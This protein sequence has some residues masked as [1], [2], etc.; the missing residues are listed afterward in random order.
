MSGQIT[1]KEI[2]EDEAIVWGPEY[3]KNVDLA[4]KKNKEFVDSI[5]SLVEANNKLRGSS[6][7]KELAENQRKVNDVS[8]KTSV[9]WKEQIQLENA[10]ISTKKKNQLASEGTNRALTKER[11]LLAESN[12]EIKRQ[13]IANGALE[14]AY[15][16][17][18]AQVAIS[19]DKIKNIIS[20]GKLASESQSQ[21]NLRLA[22]AQKEFEKLNTRVRAADAA[23]GTFNRNVGNYPQ[24]A[25]AGLKNLI[26][27]FGAVT[28]IAL[29]ASVVKDAFNATRDFEKEVVNLAAIAG[30]SRTEI[31]PLESKIREV[32]KSSINGATDVAKLAT[33]LI[34]LGSSTEEAE[35]LLEPVNN[36]S[37]ALQASAE[38]SATLV[39]SILNSYG[40]GAEEAS[41]VTDVLAESANRSALDFQG[42]RDSFSY[43][44]PAA[45]ALGIPVE[46]T[47]AIIGTLA[48]NGIK[49]ESAGRLT[50]TAF[51]RL[52]AQGLT[53]ED[54][55]LKI[56]TAQ[57]EGKSNL[58]VLSLATNL[59]G[60]EAGKI[61]LILANNVVKIDQST[62]AYENSGGALKE[63]TDKQLKSL[64][65]ELKIL[66]SAWEDY[67]LGTNEATGAS[68]KVSSVV[69][70]LSTNLEVIFTVLGSLA[71][72][73]L[74]YKAAVLLANVQ[75]RLLALT[76]TQATIAQEA[77][78]VVTG[79]GTAAQTANAAATTFAT[80]AWERFNLALKANALGLII[81]ALV[82]VIYY[83]DKYNKSLSELNNETKDSTEEFLKNREQLSKNA[84][85]TKTL[86]DR[87]DELKSKTKLNK[88][89]QIELNEIV[90]TLSKTYP[91]AV[92]KIDKYGDAIELNTS[93]IKNFTIAQNEANKAQASVEIQKNTKL[94]KELEKQQASLAESTKEGGKVTK[95]IYVQ[96]GQLYR[97]DFDG[98]EFYSTKLSLEEAANFKK[99]VADNERAVAQTKQRIRDLK[100]LTE[101][102]KVAAKT[103]DENSK[104][105]TKNSVRTIE[106]I[107]AE[108][109]AQ[110]DLVK[111]L[112]DKSGKE[113]R[114]IK[115][116]IANLTAER[117]LIY[118]TA[119]AEK[120]KQDNG[121]KNAKKVND[122]LYNLNQFRYQN[123]IN[124]NQKII[125]SEKATNEEKVNALLE[126][127][128]L[129]ESKNSETLQN[130][131]YKNALEI[132]GL[133]NLSKEKFDLYQKDAKNRIE[134]ILSGKIAT[135]KLTNDEKLILE[136]YYA[137][138]KN[139]EE[140]SSKDKQSIIDLEVARVQK[141]IDAELLAQDTKIQEALDAENTLYQN[142][143]EAAN[144]NQ[145]LIE[146]AE[147]EHQR[148]LFEIK[149]DFAK[150]GLKLQID[151]IKQLLDDDKKKEGSSKISTEKRLEYEN[152]L[153][154]L[155]TEFNQIG[156]DDFKLNLDKRAEAQKVFNEKVTELSLQLKDEL[157]N[158][159]NTI[160]EAKIS[161]ID[162]EISKNNEFYDNQIK[163]AE[164]DA[165][166]K[167]FLEKER[168]R[169]NE[170]LEKK[171]K[172]AQYEQAVFNKIMAI[173]NIGI[174]TAMA[175][176][177]AL[178]P[179]PVGLGPVA[180]GA[181]LPYIIGVGAIQAATVLA[182]PLPKYKHGRKGGP[183]E[184]A[185]VGDGGVSEIITS[186][187][188]SNPRLT[189]NVPTLT[190]LG[191]D[192]IVHK[193]MSDYENYVKQSIILNFKN[194]NQKIKELNSGFENNFSK[195]LLEEMKRN[196]KAIEKGKP[197]ILKNKAIDIPHSIWAF[198][199][200]NW[201]A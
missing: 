40:L 191:K 14:S 72:A 155:T 89:E 75:T 196:T 148:R 62:T 110:E 125:D 186:G 152:K 160:F 21:Y 9:I 157:I 143:L 177:A 181:L 74:A 95:G 43:L 83:L 114:A 147:E 26:S 140:K 53:L 162:D 84:S 25:V 10:L 33:E 2:I 17:L 39:K 12:S 182:A 73:W 1:R 78:V 8:E 176:I 172:K 105:S 102:E 23:V 106:V 38:D 200:I 129:Q 161:S 15:K 29:F 178:A 190:K 79:F 85:S 91:E 156:T 121:L 35:K 71:T 113:G 116:K 128:Q 124:N 54:A 195:E 193:S 22:V 31:A 108:I 123:E 96:N 6:N 20:T 138:K 65:S 36:L 145:K 68:Q 97:R 103:A 133:E 4:V 81:A 151:A 134:S 47:A 87:Y 164:N 77:N 86:T 141:S 67:I 100:G 94:L 63:L 76:T 61:G 174:Q 52:A 131:L 45:R 201:R 194:E 199:N 30:K 58:E 168:D 107:D 44:A 173:A 5:I 159:A 163:L 189:P 82:A 144:G 57:K 197:I 59:F 170:V 169:K 13:I 118:S 135:E 119:K 41:R 7:A 24:Q 16:K 142:A 112:S 28:G 132:D 180:G 109:K 55:L 120:E 46:K 64:D 104:T 56:N 32:S 127:N 184:L 185:I 117:E 34:K 3:A 179:P 18:A 88:E 154:K 166:K 158:F 42:L 92:T 49:A 66:S 136:K 187:D 90:K 146:K 115:S 98:R 93:K 198:R 183:A 69:K 101:A 192:D 80:S 50:S 171:K 137:E 99:R 139:L 51:S 149:K 70:F 111:G 11:V 60:A 165:R 153:A 167:D 37:V 130:D 122:A 48:D 27:A 19:G 175:S 150:K 126:I 188:G